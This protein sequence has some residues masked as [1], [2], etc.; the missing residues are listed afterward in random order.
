[1]KLPVLSLNLYTYRRPQYGLLT[2]MGLVHQV[3][4]DGEK[5]FNIVDMGSP[6]EDLEM[7]ESVVK[8]LDY[9][10]IRGDKMDLA[11]A[12]NRAAELSGEV[13]IDALDDFVPWCDW[14]I[15]GD[16]KLLLERE[17]V[18]HIKMGRL[19][20]WDY[21]RGIYGQ[22][23]KC[24]GGQHYWILDKDKSDDP[25]LCS[26]GFSLRHRR[27]ADAYYPYP[28][29]P[30]DMP[31]E[32]ELRGGNQFWENEGPTVA[33]P[34]RFGED[35]AKLGREPIWHLGHVRTDDYWKATGQRWTAS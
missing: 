8:G 21:T 27:F 9:N 29:V 13:W 33:V 35:D 2:L 10:I 12:Y 6:P 28:A 26:I 3:N 30:F 15:T 31:G 32:A 16:V 19:A 17:D 34:V 25:Y 14:D 11:T 4:Y 23:W 20:F 1:M 24:S 18:G 5:L 22:L 7:Y